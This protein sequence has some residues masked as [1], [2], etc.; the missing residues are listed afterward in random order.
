MGLTVEQL[1]DAAQRFLETG[2]PSMACLYMAKALVLLAEARPAAPVSDV[3][4]V[5]QRSLTDYF[6]ILVRDLVTVV[7]GA[8][9]ATQSD[10]ALV[11]PA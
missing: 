2:Q 10:F 1:I 8:R 4:V 9:G 6:T 11:A 7:V 5:A 3:A